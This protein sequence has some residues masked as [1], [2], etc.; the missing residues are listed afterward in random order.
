MLWGLAPCIEGSRPS[1]FLTPEFAPWN[2]LIENKAQRCVVPATRFAKPGR[3][4]S[5]P[6]Q[7]W[8]ARSNHKPF[9]FAGVWTTWWGDGSTNE[10]RSISEQR[11]YSIMITEANAV[12]RPVDDAMPVILTTAAEVEQWLTGSVEEALTLQKPPGNDVVKLVPDA[13]EAA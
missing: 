2:P 3:N 6:A 5:R 8:F 11:L 12:V 10:A 13:K 4:T 1:N 7:W 9:M